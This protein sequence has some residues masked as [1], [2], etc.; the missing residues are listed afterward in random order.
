MDFHPSHESSPEERQVQLENE[1]RRRE[2]ETK[3]GAVFTDR[4]VLPATVEAEWLRNILLFE[5]QFMSDNYTTIGA[6]LGHPTTYPVATLTDAQVDVELE[7]MFDLLAEHSIQLDCLC[8]VEPRELYRFIVEEFLDEEF[9]EIT[10]EGWWT[11]FAYEDYHPN[12][13]YDASF[14]SEM[15]LSSLLMDQEHSLKA[16]TECDESAR[17]ANVLVHE[18]APRMMVFWSHYAV[19]TERN[20]DSLACEVN[21]DNA[22]TQLSVAFTGLLHGCNDPIRTTGRAVLRLTRSPYGGWD[23]VHASVPGIIM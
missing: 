19:I 12:D 4:N 6:V 17:E 9:I 1:A 13:E 11:F 22:C 18:L 10:A 16:A 23:V 15:F 7:Q 2:L 3:Y 21:G 14:W 20:I 5:E 8:E